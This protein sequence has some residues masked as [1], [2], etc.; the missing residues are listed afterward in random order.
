MPRALACALYP[1]LVALLACNASP[2]LAAEPSAPQAT[3][4]AEPAPAP[5]VTAS[6]APAHGAPDPRLPIVGDPLGLLSRPAPSQVESASARQA[7]AQRGFDPGA[8][9]ASA[10]LAPQ[11]TVPLERDPRA[12][13]RA[14]QAMAEPAQRAV[15]HTRGPVVVQEK[16][17]A[18]VIGGVRKSAPRPHVLFLYAS[19]CRACRNVLP[20]FLPLVQYY[21]GRNVLFTAASVDRDLSSYESYAPVLNGV[22]PP[23]LIRS[24]GETRNELIRAGL[25]FSGDSYSIPLVAVFD[26]GHRLVRQGGSNEFA[27]LAQ[28]L[29]GLIQ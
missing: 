23:V 20:N 29:D 27:R 13:A 28:T 25:S 1:T 14:A 7:K 16:S 19:Y 5:A 22:L 2:R 17:A 4:P 26:K 11:T 6:S 21:K 24:E 8:L 18:E 3:A 10:N 15:P 9:M 12:V